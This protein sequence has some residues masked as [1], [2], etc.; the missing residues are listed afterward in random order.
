MLRVRHNDYIC[1]RGIVAALS[2]VLVTYTSRDCCRWHIYH[3]YYWYGEVV[4]W[5]SGEEGGGGRL[6]LSLGAGMLSIAL[7]QKRD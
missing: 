2:N 3:L 4:G 7:G 5:G 6:E 1:E